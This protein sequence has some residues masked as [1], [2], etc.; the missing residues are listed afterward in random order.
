MK[1]S[2]V[3][4]LALHNVLKGNPEYYHRRICRW[5]SEKFATPLEHVYDIPNDD[6]YLHYFECYFEGLNEAERQEEVKESLKTPEQVAQEEKD[7][8]LQSISDAEFFKKAQREA[9]QEAKQKQAMENAAAK[10]QALAE[11]FK[12]LPPKDLNTNQKLNIPR[13]IPIPD[14]LPDDEGTAFGFKLQPNAKKKKP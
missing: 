6:I 14:D 11:S 10:M 7:Q 3:R 5:Y 9:E 12:K 2:D 1:I 4:L 13:E 8:I